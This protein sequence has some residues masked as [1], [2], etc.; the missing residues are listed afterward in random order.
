MVPARGPHLAM[1]SS[2]VSSPAL[3]DS[4]RVGSLT[5]APL[6]RVPPK[7]ITQE[8]PHVAQSH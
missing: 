1:A 6:S 3:A 7:P 2:S 4:R 8:T 5:Q